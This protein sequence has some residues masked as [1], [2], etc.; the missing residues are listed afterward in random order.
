MTPEPVISLLLLA[1]GLGSRFGGTKQLAPVGPQGSAI[2]DHSIREAAVAGVTRV[3]VIGR[4]DLDRDI[5]RHLMTQHGD[6]LDLVMVHQDAFG[7]ARAKPWGTG[8]A[9]VS[10]HAVLDGPVV[11]LNADDHYGPTGIARIASAVAEP[12]GQMPVAAMLG[13]RLGRT[14]PA[15]GTV[16]RG[17]CR[18]DSDGRLAGLVETHGIG[19]DNNGAQGEV[20]RAADPPGELSPETPVSM[21]IWALPLAAI[22]VLR[23]QWMAFH[24][25]HRYSETA[26]FLLPEALDE[27]RAGGLLSIQ[28]LDT[29][30]NWI[31]ITNRG[32]LEVARDA[33]A[34][35]AQG[36][37]CSPVDEVD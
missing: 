1:G 34:A 9:V 37:A 8:H 4:T 35:L 12:A 2:L 20:I 11:V 15:T 17:V 25:E 13:F 23:E 26:E 31:G 24:D 27:Q 14:L 3:V 7:P 5:R 16:S 21:N 10:A 6:D 18:R 33:F 29:D 36:R 19:R 30:E 22:E 28:V 32:D